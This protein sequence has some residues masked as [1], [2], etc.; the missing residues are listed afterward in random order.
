[1]VTIQTGPEGQTVRKVFIEDGCE[2]DRELYLGIVLDRAASLPVLMASTEGGVEIEKVAEETPDKIFK[3][4]FDPHVGLHGY[5][6]RKLCRR[7][8]LKGPTVRKCREIH[9]D[10][11]PTLRPAGLQHGGD[12]SLGRHEVGRNGRPRCED[13][14]R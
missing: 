7:L 13:H 12:Q 2:I 1:L 11:L 4:H 8:G 9:E 3:E 5:Q 10:A 14:F 6:V